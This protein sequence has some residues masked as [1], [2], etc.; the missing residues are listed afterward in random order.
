MP[1]GRGD[2]S[3]SCKSPA[4]RRFFC[5]SR[6]RSAIF[7]RPLADLTLD[8]FEVRELLAQYGPAG[9]IEPAVE[10]CGIDPAEVDGEAWIAILEVDQVGI[11]AVE[12]A[13]DPRHPDPPNE[14]VEP[15]TYPAEQ[16]TRFLLDFRA[17]IPDS[18]FGPSTERRFRAQIRRCARPDAPSPPASPA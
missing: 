9:A 10:D 6:L 15:L 13:P 14:L 7:I 1:T 3:P 11:W 2:G 8:E 18:L 16:V 4:T 5:R 12:A 17:V